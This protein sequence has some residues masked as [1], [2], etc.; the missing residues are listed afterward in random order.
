M[1]GVA[2]WVGSK[3]TPLFILRTESPEPTH[4]KDLQGIAYLLSKKV[5]QKQAVLH[6]RGGKAIP[7]D[8]KPI[9]SKLSLTVLLVTILAQNC[10]QRYKSDFFFIFHT[11]DA[12]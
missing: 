7:I 3:A 1:W 6:M 5:C 11:R 4:R 8:I 10:M 9:K 2:K 12:I